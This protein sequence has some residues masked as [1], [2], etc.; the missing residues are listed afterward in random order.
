MKFSII[1]STYRNKE[2][3]VQAANSLIAQTYK[4]W[5]MIVIND[6]PNDAAYHTFIS[7]IND[8]RIYYHQNLIT[9]GKNHNNNLGLDTLSADSKWVIFLDDTA[10]L[11]PDTLATLHNLII[12]NGD[13]KWFVTN[14]AYKNGT[15]ITKFPHDNT[16]YSYAVDSLL[17]RKCKGVATHCIETKLI[18]QMKARFSQYERHSEEWFFFYQV[19]LHTKMYYRDHN[20]TISSDVMSPHYQ[21]LNE[22]FESITKIFYEGLTYKL[23]YHPTFVLY[24]IMKYLLILVKK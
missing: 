24:I 23:I 12:L 8:P 13:K 10:Y 22:R 19:G 15:P 3:L 6:S 7:G 4:D 1:T 18:T 14:C 17:L 21:Y 5:E 11:S 9:E 2:R 16:S 20:S